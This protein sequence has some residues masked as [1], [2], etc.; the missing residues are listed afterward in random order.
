MSFCPFPISHC[1][2]CLSSINGFWLVI[3]YLQSFPLRRKPITISRRPL[4]SLMVNHHFP[5]LLDYSEKPQHLLLF[6]KS[7]VTLQLAVFVILCSLCSQFLWN[8]HFWFPLRY[9]LTFIKEPCELST[10][11]SEDIN[12]L[13]R[14][15]SVTYIQL[16]IRC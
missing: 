13:L 10:R 8:I 12:N 14:N 6:P 15:Y 1:V 5:R 7:S 11:F 16:A 9:S 2:V 3:W 4:D